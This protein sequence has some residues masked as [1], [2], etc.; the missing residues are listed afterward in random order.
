MIGDGDEVGVGDFISS[1]PLILDTAKST[2]SCDEVAVDNGRRAYFFCSSG[3]RYGSSPIWNR[4]YTLN[5]SQLIF[6]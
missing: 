4:S 2:C 5:D 6:S 3:C 1:F